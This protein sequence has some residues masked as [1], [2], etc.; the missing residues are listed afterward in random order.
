MHFGRRPPNARVADF[1]QIIRA[2]HNGIRKKP[3]RARQIEGGCI[4]VLAGR[5]VVTATVS[6]YEDFGHSSGFE[7]AR[8]DRH[9]SRLDIHFRPRS[10]PAVQCAEA[11]MT[12]AATIPPPRDKQKYQAFKAGGLP[13]Y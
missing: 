6:H 13:E 4:E 7:A 10:L 5:A 3:R 9:P 12:I 1:Y 2:G 11:G 8:N